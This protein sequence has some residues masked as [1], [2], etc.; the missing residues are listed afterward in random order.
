MDEGVRANKHWGK[1]RIRFKAAVHSGNLFDSLNDCQ[2]KYCMWFEEHGWSK[3]SA[4]KDHHSV[5]ARLMRAIQCLMDDADAEEPTSTAG[6]CVNLDRGYGHVDAQ[7]CAKDAGVHTNTVMQLNRVGLPRQWLLEIKKLLGACQG[8]GGGDDDDDDDDAGGAAAPPPKQRQK[9][10]CSTPKAEDCN[11]FSFSV[12]H[13]G[14]WEL[15]VWQDSKLIVCLTSF[16]S[17]TRAG[18]LAR[19]SHSSKF[20]YEVWA[21]EGIWYYNVEGRSATDGNDQERKKLAIAERRCVRYGLKGMHFV[22]DLAFTNG[23]II[24]RGLAPDDLPKSD[25]HLLTKVS[26]VLAWAQEQ[27]DHRT[28]ARKRTPVG[29]CI[30]QAAAT[31]SADYANPASA[32]VMQRTEHELV[33]CGSVVRKLGFRTC[34]TPQGPKKRKCIPNGA[35]YYEGCQEDT[36]TTQLRCGSCKD[37]KGAFFHLPC[38]FATHRC[39]F[40]G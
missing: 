31:N 40:A 4:G 21:P 33:N 12:V 16:F 24:S 23:A 27:F 20:S 32:H 18:L 2:T 22:F 11:K 39:T 17:G 26:F 6:Y 36:K 30:L 28:P 5:K 35:C 14:D 3:R 13:K 19:G 9:G 37:G 7:Q 1:E 25:Q 34:K 8:I 15:Q 38:F 10:G 29:M